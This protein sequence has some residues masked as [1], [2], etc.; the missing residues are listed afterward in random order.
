MSKPTTNQLISPSRVMNGIKLPSSLLPKLP[1]PLRRSLSASAPPQR[2]TADDI[3]Q[4]EYVNVTG[5]M[6]LCDFRP[7]LFAGNAGIAGTEPDYIESLPEKLASSACASACASASACSRGVYICSGDLARFVTQV[8]PRI[9][10][11][12][13]LVTG[14][15]DMTMPAEAL[16][17]Q[18]LSELL[19]NANLVR[20]FAQNLLYVHPKLANWPLGLSYNLYYEDRLVPTTAVAQEAELKSVIAGMKPFYE[21]DPRRLVYF[22]MTM[23]N[24]RIEDRWEVFNKIYTSDPS[25]FVEGAALERQL[26]SQ[27]VRDGSG[28]AVE[29]KAARTPRLDVWKNIATSVFAVSPCGYG[30]DCHRTYE[31]LALGAIPIVRTAAVLGDLFV[32]MPVLVVAEWADVT[33]TLLERTL[34][35]FGERARQGEYDYAC[36]KIAYWRDRI[37]IT[38]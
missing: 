32:G 33:R 6:A 31:I 35:E 24:G 25:I 28:R 13:V 21:R 10:T 16:T 18:Q 1:S 30:L 5:L 26:E 15:S 11:P 19:G 38:L 2:A 34:A 17:Q 22:N 29:N 8:L 23:R 14:D 12:F 3:T 20:W 36:L 27:I 9:D 37:R 7:P 4:C